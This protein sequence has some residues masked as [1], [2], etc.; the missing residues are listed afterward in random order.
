[1]GTSLV[2][3][4]G[5][6][7]LSDECD[8]ESIIVPGSQNGRTAVLHSSAARRAR[9]MDVP[10]AIPPLSPA[11]PFYLSDDCDSELII[12]SGSPIAGSNQYRRRRPKGLGH[13]WPR[14]QSRL[15]FSRH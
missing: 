7:Y 11:G 2:F 12:V 10:S 13:G 14:V 9:H 1:M 8:S 5:P 15:F 4:L 3:R 6:F